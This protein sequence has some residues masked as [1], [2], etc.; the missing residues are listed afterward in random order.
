MQKQFNLNYYLAK[1][2]VEAFLH[3]ALKTIHRAENGD[4]LLLYESQSRKKAYSE[5]LGSK[6]GDV[7][8]INIERVF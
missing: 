5:R 3:K 8:L 7:P 6:T 4:T 1:A 2:F